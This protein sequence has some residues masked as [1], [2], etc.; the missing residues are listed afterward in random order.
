MPETKYECNK[1]HQVFV[2]ANPTLNTKCPSCGGFLS[3]K[4]QPLGPVTPVITVAGVRISYV[5]LY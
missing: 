2:F 1:C 4:Y 3:R 5:E